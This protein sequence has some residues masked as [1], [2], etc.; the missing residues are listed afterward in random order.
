[1]SVYAKPKCESFTCTQKA[2]ESSSFF[3]FW[4]PVAMVNIHKMS[5]STFTHSNYEQFDFLKYF[6]KLL[7]WAA[8]AAA[9]TTKAVKRLDHHEKLL[10]NQNTTRKAKRFEIGWMNFSENVQDCTVE[11][12]CGYCIFVSLFCAFSGSWT[13]HVFVLMSLYFLNIVAPLL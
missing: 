11:K 3:I 10:G 8:K 6:A 12:K 1:M 4:S 7:I 13:W 9:P 5:L 2:V